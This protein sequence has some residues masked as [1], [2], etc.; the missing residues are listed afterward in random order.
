MSD[1][2]PSKPGRQRVALVSLGCPKNQ[3]DSELILGRLRADGYQVVADPDQA[4]TLVVNT[5]AFVENARAESVHALIE[6]V[7]WKEVDSG[8]RRIIAAGCLVQRHG[9][10]LRAELPEIDGWLGLDDIA[11][12]TKITHGAQGLTKIERLPSAGPARGLF[13]HVDPRSRLSPPWSAYVKISE[14]CDQRCAFCAIPTFR[15]RNRSRSIEDILAELAQLA[16]DGVVEANLIAQDS[17]GWGRDLGLHDGLPE[18]V[19]AIDTSDKA[20]DWIRIH[21]LYPGRISERLIEALSATRRFVE[22]IDLPLQHAHPQV[23]QRMRRPGNAESY[24]RHLEALQRALPGAGIRSGFIV[25]FPGESEAEFQT[26]CDFVAAAPLDAA[27]VF[28]YS[29]ERSTSAYELEDDVPEDV[30]RARKEILEE[31]VSDVA[32]ERAQTRIGATLEV[33]VEGA[34]PDIEAAFEGRW[35]GQ[36]PDVDGRVVIENASGLRPGARVR[37]QIIDAAPYDLIGELVTLP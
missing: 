16:D 24:L 4:D 2:S 18:L 25:G 23:L 35:R 34:A 1:A 28:A 8:A 10:E 31:I 37:C 29:H 30:K 9:D 14:G 26:L 21:Y 19:R 7:R 27:G 22:Y 32:L 5:C 12:T 33:L 3:V 36:A 13:S 17:T 15:G 11:A 6:A 20:P